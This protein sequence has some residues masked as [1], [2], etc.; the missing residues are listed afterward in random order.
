METT[1]WRQSGHPFNECGFILWL[2]GAK[3][4]CRYLRWAEEVLHYLSSYDTLSILRG[5]F[6]SQN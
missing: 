4:G 5:A 6:I 3:G 2:C 1:M